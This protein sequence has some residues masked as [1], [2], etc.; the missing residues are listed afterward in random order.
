MPR[1]R[2]AEGVA[3]VD[4]LVI[5]EYEVPS[6]KLQAP[7][8]SQ[9]PTLHNIRAGWRLDIGSALGFGAWSLGVELKK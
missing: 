6:S 2:G 8:H 7:T 5:R 4:C 9:H 3:L 1:T